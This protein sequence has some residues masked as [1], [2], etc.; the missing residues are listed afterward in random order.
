MMAVIILRLL[1]LV[2]ILVL[3]YIAINGFILWFNTNSKNSKTTKQTNK[4]NGTKI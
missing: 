1:F 2:L 3:G 4:K